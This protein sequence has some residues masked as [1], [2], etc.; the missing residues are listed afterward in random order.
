MS[1]ADKKANKIFLFIFAVAFFAVGV[2]LQQCARDPVP[3]TLFPDIT[4]TIQ[5]QK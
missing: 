3:E 4:N 5:I 1:Q 2:L